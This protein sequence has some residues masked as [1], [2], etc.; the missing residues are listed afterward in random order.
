MTSQQ[1]AKKLIAPFFDC[2]VSPD[3]ITKVVV[4]IENLW[5]LQ[6]NI[7]LFLLRKFEEGRHVGRDH[8]E[9]K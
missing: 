5:Q 6:D 7:E 2:P 9:K 3:D 1:L 4:P 8:D